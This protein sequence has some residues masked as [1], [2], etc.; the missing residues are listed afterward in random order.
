MTDS[1]EQRH[2]QVEHQQDREHHDERDDRAGER[3]DAADCQVLDGVA[4]DVDT[5]HG[6]ARAG[7]D[8]VLEA[9]RL[10]VF[11][12]PVAQVVDHA[13][14][15]AGLQPDADGRGDLVNQLQDHA[16]QDEQHEQ[17]DGAAARESARPTL[18]RLGQVV[19]AEHVVDDDL[20]WPRLECTESDLQQHRA[21]R[22]RSRARDRGA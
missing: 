13:L 5:V 8:V 20:Q 4:V 9:E 18:E 10:Q 21:G 12:Q 1:E 2:R 19:L 14:A 11:E 7:G 17:S 16:R 3:E 15:R 6:V 22:R